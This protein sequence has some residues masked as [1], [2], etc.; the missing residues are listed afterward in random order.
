[1]IFDAFYNM[2]IRWSH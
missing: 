2:L 1:M